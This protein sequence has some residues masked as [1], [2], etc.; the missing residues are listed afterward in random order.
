MSDT[1]GPLGPSHT[2]VIAFDPDELSSMYPVEDLIVGFKTKK[3]DFAD[4]PCPPRSAMVRLTPVLLA[5]S[6]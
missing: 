6:V 4:L 5:F 1:C 3:F 2:T